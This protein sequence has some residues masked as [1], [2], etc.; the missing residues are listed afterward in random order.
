M[1]IDVHCHAMGNGRKFDTKA[2]DDIYYLPE[3]N[4]GLIAKVVAYMVRYGL[5][6]YHVQ[7]DRH[8]VVK[9]AS[10][11][12]LLLELLKSSHSIDGIVI[13]AL[14]AVYDLG[15]KEADKAK[16]DLFVPNRFLWEKI[17]Q[18]NEELRS[19]GSTKRF[20]FGASVNPNRQDWEQ[21]LDFVINQT[22]AVLL[23]W[24]PSAMHIQPWQ[25][26]HLL[27]YRKLAERELP[28]LCHVGPE[29]TF[30]EGLR[31]QKYDYYGHLKLALDAGVKII[32]AHCGLP[33][34]PQ[35]DK[36]HT[37]QPHSRPY[38]VKDFAN[39]MKKYNTDTDI[40]I[41]T[42][43]SALLLLTR[44]DLIEEVL[45]YIPTKWMV[46]GTDFPI[47]IDR[48]DSLP[49][50]LRRVFTN[51]RFD[52]PECYS[53]NPFDRDIAFQACCRIPPSIAENAEKVLRMSPS[54]G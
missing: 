42:D 7:F 43:T 22:D 19:L 36:V 28:L 23:K 10:Y 53:K 15:K 11:F 1:R 6:E 2:N 46:H 34:I 9:T 14:D 45:E 20:F 37:L 25:R 13:L 51:I 33:V 26:R 41:W 44:S 52:D 49:T 18:M 39:F 8:R 38:R 24:I 50:I 40:R 48:P 17:K 30:T 31:H 32:A 27:F 16:T 12:R 5:E 21:E 4:F 47:P 3:D 54:E 35:F 29:Y